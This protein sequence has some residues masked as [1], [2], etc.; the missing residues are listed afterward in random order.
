MKTKQ[1]I[2]DKIEILETRRSNFIIGLDDSNDI[3]VDTLEW[4]KID[5]KIGEL[6]WVL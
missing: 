6:R 1:E 3:F 5:S 2:L 4:E